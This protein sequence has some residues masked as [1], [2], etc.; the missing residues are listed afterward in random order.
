MYAPAFIRPES[1]AVDP[2]RAAE[3]SSTKIR[4]VQELSTNEPPPQD[5]IDGIYFLL[6]S[7][8]HR[9]LLRIHVAYT[10]EIISCSITYIHALNTH[11]QW[12]LVLI[13]VA[14]G[15]VLYTIR[16]TVLPMLIN[17]GHDFEFHTSCFGISKFV[18]FLNCAAVIEC[19]YFMTNC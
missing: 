16:D 17:K 12:G 11:L 1:I 3:Q 6:K 10:H 18:L 9:N 7:I 15:V 2:E 14:V 4:P 8:A 5:S 13:F 19:Y